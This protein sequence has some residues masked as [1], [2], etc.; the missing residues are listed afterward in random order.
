M[1]CVVVLDNLCAT[2]WAPFSMKLWERRVRVG[3]DVKRTV[4]AVKNPGD[5]MVDSL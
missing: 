3:A 1:R 5:A 2:A 4:E